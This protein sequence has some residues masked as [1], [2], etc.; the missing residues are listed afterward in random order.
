MKTETRKTTRWDRR[1][2]LKAAGMGTLVSALSPL[3]LVPSKLYAQSLNPL[4][5]FSTFFIGHGGYMSRELPTRWNP[6]SSNLIEREVGIPV[7]PNAGMKHALTSNRSIAMEPLTNFLR[8]NAEGQLVLNE[9]FDSRWT[10][11]GLIEYLNVFH[12]FY[13]PWYYGHGEA[14]LGDTF[15][16]HNASAPLTGPSLSEVVGQSPLYMPQQGNSYKMPMVVNLGIETKRLVNPDDIHSAIEI[17][18]NVIRS[19]GVYQATLGMAQSLSPNGN[20]LGVA[21]LLEEVQRL[22]TRPGVSFKD[23]QRLE[24]HQDRLLTLLQ[25]VQDGSCTFTQD[26]PESPPWNQ[27]HWNADE[28]G[29][30]EMHSQLIA[31]YMALAAAS[32]GRAV[33]SN[34]NAGTFTRAP[35][36]FGGFHAELAHFITSNNNVEERVRRMK[37]GYTPWIRNQLG[38]SVFDL[39]LA[40]KNTPAGDGKNLLDH[41][42]IVVAMEAGPRTH[43]GRGLTLFTIGGASGRLKTGLYVDASQAGEEYSYGGG[44][45]RIKSDPLMESQFHRRGL[46]LQNLLNTICVAAGLSP[47]R[48]ELNPGQGFFR[49]SQEANPPIP[50]GAILN[51]V[52]NL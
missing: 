11:N 22:K 26:L 18:P 7:F 48:Y 35:R 44:T 29:Y 3:P 13:I 34:M 19:S 14:V 30:R 23:Q 17:A 5:L 36:L 46:P 51:P 12:N 20:S 16:G 10:T 38:R 4:Q 25:T 49:F 43:Q 50:P 33:I 15:T 8:Q 41:S 21:K 6:N 2:F 27:Y 1:S 47:D 37:L 28:N 24:A 32:C 45:E 9:V 52:L 39:A 40:L 31:S 42:L